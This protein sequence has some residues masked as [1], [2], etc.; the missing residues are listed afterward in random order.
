VTHAAVNM[1]C[2]DDVDDA[3]VTHVAVSLRKSPLGMSVN[4][5]DVIPVA[6][7]TEEAGGDADVAQ[8]V[9]VTN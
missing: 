2:D 1:R 5:A 6:V 7:I 3:G 4:D 8:G 9:A